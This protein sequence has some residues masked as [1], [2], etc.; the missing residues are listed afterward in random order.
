MNLIV[1]PGNAVEGISFPVTDEEIERLKVREPGYEMVDITDAI[2]GQTEGLIFAFIA[3]DAEYPG[4]KIPQSYLNACLGAVPESLRA[5]WL[6]E[7]IIQNEI[8]E[9]SSSPVYEF[10]LK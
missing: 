9:D 3:P 8:L 2:Q 4:I 7:T 5:V 10:A 6:K 1:K